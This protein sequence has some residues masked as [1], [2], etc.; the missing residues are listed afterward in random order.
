M[1]SSIPTAARNVA[2]TAA[3]RIAIAAVASVAVNAGAESGRGTF[4]EW[5]LL[6]RVEGS[7][8]AVNLFPMHP[9]CAFPSRVRVIGRGAERRLTFFEPNGTLSGTTPLHPSER[10]LPAIHGTAYLIWSAEETS[11]KLFRYRYFSHGNPEPDWEASAPGEP[12]LFAPDGSFFVIASADTGRDGFQRAIATGG[13]VQVVGAGGD[14][15]GELP[16]YPAYVRCTGDQKRIALLHENELVVLGADGR[17]DWN[18]RLPIDALPRRE[19]ISQLEAAGGVIVACG[20]GETKES[21]VLRLKRRGTLHAFDD[22]GTQLW[23]VQQP[24]GEDLWFQPSCALSPD[25]G[26]LAMF[27]SNGREIVVQAWDARSGERL[28]RRSV[29]RYPGARQLSVAPHGKW[30]VLASGDLRTFVLAWD[31]EG[32]VV[33][34]GTLPFPSRQPRMRSDHLLESA[35]WIV[36]L[37]ADS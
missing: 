12:M 4:G 9:E 18:V 24:D 29:A 22:T 19:G 16:F 25:G 7:G 13:H 14:V 6:W 11:T 21:T 17:L 30:V 15:L 37:T 28:W 32:T 23:A 3:M 31:R 27:H 8:E 2:R 20:T 35:E 10:A 26:T 33:F 36:R 34:E 1:R 5:E